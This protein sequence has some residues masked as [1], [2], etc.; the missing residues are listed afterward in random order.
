M[1]LD[2]DLPER[3]ASQFSLFEV[4]VR[5]QR[6]H[7]TAL[8]ISRPITNLRRCIYN[9]CV[10][11]QRGPLMSTNLILSSSTVNRAQVSALLE[12]TARNTL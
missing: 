3:T 5:E 2:A 1:S 10:E 7:P 9:H 12:Y 11:T 4:R 8:R 6:G